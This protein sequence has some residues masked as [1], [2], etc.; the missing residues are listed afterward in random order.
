MEEL[1]KIIKKKYK[2]LGQVIRDNNITRKRKRHE[3]YPKER[4]G[5]LTDT[6]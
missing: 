6:E 4:Y 3:H 5:K 2:H 1:H